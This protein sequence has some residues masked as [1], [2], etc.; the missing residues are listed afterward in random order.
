MQRGC[1]VEEDQWVLAVDSTV[2]RAHHD[3]AGARH[4]P[5][6]DVPAGVLT[7]ALDRAAKPP[8]AASSEV[9]ATPE[10]VT[11]GATK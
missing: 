3:A 8:A 10:L 6:V 7:P 2:V 9:V 11:G 4:Q 5:P 1:D